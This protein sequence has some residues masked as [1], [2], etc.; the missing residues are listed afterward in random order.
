[1]VGYLM[2]RGGPA[3]GL[4]IEVVEDIPE[5]GVVARTPACEDGIGWEWGLLPEGIV[6]DATLA[7]AGLQPR[8]SP[9]VPSKA[10]VACETEPRLLCFGVGG[11]GIR[12]GER[13]GQRSITAGKIAVEC[14]GCEMADIHQRA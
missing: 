13:R 10:E 5:L 9:H 12:G 1:L 6:V 8:P 7:G 4:L 11:M 14:C 2:I 3:P